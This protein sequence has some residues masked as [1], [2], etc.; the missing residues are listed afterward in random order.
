MKHFLKLALP[1]FIGF[2]GFLYIVMTTPLQAAPAGLYFNPGSGNFTQGQE[3]IVDIYGTA[4]SNFGAPSTNVVVKYP[5]DSLAVVE[6]NKTSSAIPA[7][8]LTSTPA[9]QTV[10]FTNTIFGVSAGIDNK[11]LFAIKFRTLKPGPAVLDFTSTFLGGHTVT[12]TPS[13]Y[14]IAAPTCPAGQIGTPPNCTTPP[15][16]TCPTGQVGTPPN[17]TT[18]APTP[19]PTK[20]TTPAAPRQP[21]ATPTPTPATPN[22]SIPTQPTEQQEAKPPEELAIKD[23][24]VIPSYDTAAITWQSNKKMKTSS[25]AYGTSADKLDNKAVVTNDEAGL[26]SQTKIAKLQLG[27]QYFYTITITSDDSATVTQKG[28]FTTKAYPVLLR[29]SHNRQPIAKGK[30]QLTGFDESYTTSDKG[31]VALSLKPGDYTFTFTKD[32]ISEEQKFTVKKL[33]IQPGKAPDT[34]VVAVDISATPQTTAN[35]SRLGAIVAGTFLFLLLIGS[36]VG[37]LIWKK[38]RQSQDALGYQSV[39]DDFAPM[40]PDISEGGAGAYQPPTPL[41][42]PNTQPDYIAPASYMTTPYQGQQLVGTTEPEHTTTLEEP[43]NDIWDA[44]PMPLA[45]QAATATELSQQQVADIPTSEA[46]QPYTYAEVQTSAATQDIEYAANNES[47]E[48]PLAVEQPAAYQASPEIDRQLTTP[49]DEYEYNEDNS[50]TIHH[51]S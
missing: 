38:R 49:A 3:F 18:P 40:T 11:K 50:M 7:A 24:S 17:C 14:T 15:P 47:Y 1:I 12:K 25:L 27:V 2:T 30:V 8:T 5:G 34:Q 39:I 19:T 45:Q 16:P 26:E 9:Q 41:T 20:P 51:S 6:V 48:P 36:I 42:Y 4:P 29:I 21:A 32:A 10:S 44:T 23:I 33:D 22:T 46:S 37:F 35:S 31:E 28:S 13:T 43:S